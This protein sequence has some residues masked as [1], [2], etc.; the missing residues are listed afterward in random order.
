[1][2]ELECEWVWYAHH[3]SASNTYSHAYIEIG[4]FKTVA[5]FWQYYNACPSATNIHDGT[6]VLNGQPVIAYSLF[7]AGV[8]PEW[9]DVVNHKGS[10]WGCRELLDRSAFQAF[11]DIYIL[12]AI[13]E[14][15][16]HCVGVRA[17][18]KCN[19]SRSMH[20]LEVWLDRHDLISA[21]ATR[22]VLLDLAPSFSTKFTLMLHDVKQSQALEYQRRRRQPT[23]PKKRSDRNSQKKTRSADAIQRGSRRGSGM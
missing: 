17:I 10:E 11:W 1:M 18:N 13:G 4:R 6:I 23:S 3:P 21:Y 14:Q 22:K 7:R 12:A 9:E 20:K 19:R 2:C 15:I 5:M 16:P 8:R